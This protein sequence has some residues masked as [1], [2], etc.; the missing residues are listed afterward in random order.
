MYADYAFYKEIYLG[1]NIT[2]ADFDRLMSRAGFYLQQITGG[3]IKKQ[4]ETD[5]V[6]MAA[7]A[8]AEVWQE[9]EQGGSVV[10]ESVG[11]WSKTYADQGKTADKKLYEAAAMYLSSTG[12]LSRWC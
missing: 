6:K 7:C 2:E 9:K 12:L 1:N 8:V 5:A 11:K 3:S 10:S 4:A